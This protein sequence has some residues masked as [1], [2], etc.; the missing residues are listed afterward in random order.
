LILA[1]DESFQQSLKRILY[2]IA[3][4][5]IFW[6]AFY[7]WYGGGFPDLSRV[8]L[9]FFQ[10]IFNVEVYHLYYLV[11][12]MGLYFFAPMLRV[13]LSVVSQSAQSFF[14][15]TLIFLGITMTALEFIFQG[16]L[17]QNFFTMWLPYVGFFVA[18]HVLGQNAGKVSSNKLYVGYSIGLILTLGLNFLHFY[19]QAHNYTFFSQNGCL[20]HYS[21][22]YLSFNVVLMSLCAF[23]LLLQFKLH[24]LKENF[25]GSKI[26]KSLAKAS[27]GIYL[28]H[29]V[30]GRLLEMQFHLAIDFSP[31]PIGMII[32]L[33]FTLV[34]LL[35]YISVLVLSKIPVIK[36]IF[37]IR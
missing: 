4:P 7:L 8:N 5:F 35:S 24:R 18:G 32:L 19:L 14:M 9:S 2:R 31:L 29:P 28:I 15:K 12:V 26:V 33:K 25:L 20:S 13:Y 10:K 16:C 3:L 1:K 27:F 37:G 36:F 22:H 11:I 21:D 30:I 6:F 17:S 34:L 23:L